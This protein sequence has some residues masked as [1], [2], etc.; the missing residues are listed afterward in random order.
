MSSSSYGGA[1]PSGPFGRSG[2]NDP[3]NLALYPA[4]PQYDLATI[5]QLVGVRPMALWAWEQQ[6]GIPRPERLGDSSG[7]TVRH[8]SE[9][10]LVAAIWLRNQILA[11][12]QPQ[13]AADLLNQAQK[14]YKAAGI[15]EPNGQ[16]GVSGASF[17][18]AS[19]SLSGALSGT[20]FPQR[21][22]M[23]GAPASGE[24][25][26]FG[27]EGPVRGSPTGTWG[28]INSANPGGSVSGVRRPIPSGPLARGRTSGPFGVSRGGLSGPLTYGVASGRTSGPLGGSVTRG[29]ATGGRATLGPGGNRELR[30]LVQPLLRAFA[31]FDT[32]TAN[33]LV[34]E[35]LAAHSV[36][37]VCVG[38]LQPALNRVGE[39][40]ARHEMTSPEEHYGL[41]FVRGWLYAIFTQTQ[42]RFDGPL[43][44]VTCAPRESNEIGAL[45][46]A[47]FWRRAGM[48]VVFLGQ[49]LDGQALVQDVELRR[50]RIVCVCI[51]SSQRVR[52]LA[53][54][55]KG[56]LSI[57]APTPQF[58]YSGP[59][60]ARNPELQHKVSGRYLGDDPATATWH[61]MRL[62]GVDHSGE[63]S[64]APASGQAGAPP[65]AAG[66]A[67]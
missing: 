17:G 13:E 14:Q 62:L 60:F 46:L 38:L 58:V 32:L 10:D 61:A 63:G 47:T 48:R 29:P 34:E 56:V 49:D 57:S 20:R 66:N 5:V 55:A 3:P 15:G 41:N 37:T 39:L 1:P 6:L 54:I 64:P 19:G 36:E 25:G 53:K 30:S 7:G 65:S 44:V 22:G 67:G 51:T 4:D 24:F 27:A 31:T 50:P 8:Y 33:G 18:P 23:T 35:A 28:P 16:G 52:A 45:M 59:V 12:L 42:E 21:G 43:A 11:G 2:K 40:W 9:R 26:S